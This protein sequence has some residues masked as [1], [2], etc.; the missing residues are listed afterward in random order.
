M[1]YRLLPCLLGLLL[2]ASPLAAQSSVWKITRGD[3]T[4][5]LGGTCHVLRASDR[6]LPAEFDQAFAASQV[7]YFETDIARLQS[8]EMQAF[9]LTEGM[10]APGQ[11]LQS[12]LTPAT[13]QAAQR[14]AKKA[15]LPAE[16]FAAMKPW[17]FTVMMAVLE[18]QKLGISSEGV[19]L[20]YFRR[21]ADAGKK[22]GGLEEFD[23]H[24]AYL[25]HL[26]EGHESEMIAQAIDD[27]TELPTLL[28]G[29]LAAWKIGD[30]AKLDALMLRDLRTKY[31]SIYQQLIVARN[32]AW[33]PKIEALVQTP[34]VEFVLA[35]VG[36]MAGKDGLLERLRAKGYTVTQLKAAPPT[37]KSPA[38]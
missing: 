28:D 34:E 30:V 7:V 31:P 11:T 12:V 33:L 23:R 15:G 24:L 21:A 6:P 27:L 20:H 26:G 9:V 13:W 2:G 16:Q 35:G 1:P 17:L 19:D 36:H 25:S 32:D 18:M 4:L 22:T 3:A 37:K 5:Y 8:P 38:K 29:L 14:Y 10:F